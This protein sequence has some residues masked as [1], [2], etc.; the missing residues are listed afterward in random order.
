[1]PATSGVS[2]S[3]CI[4][5]LARHITAYGSISAFTLRA[6]TLYS[7]S[8]SEGLLQCQQGPGPGPG[9]RPGPAP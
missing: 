9:Q 3:M 8:K 5:C 1:M 2:E 7:S 4:A 6:A